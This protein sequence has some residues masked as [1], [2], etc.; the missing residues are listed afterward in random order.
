LNILIPDLTEADIYNRFTGQ[1]FVHTHLCPNS[2]NSALNLLIMCLD[3]DP[4]HQLHTFIN[5]GP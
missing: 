5:N 2:R 1:K 3:M 4:L